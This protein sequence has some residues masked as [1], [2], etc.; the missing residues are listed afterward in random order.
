[1][2]LGI[3]TILVA[4]S[5]VATQA[6]PVVG[7]GPDMDSKYGKTCI[8][9][10]CHP[11]P[12]FGT[13]LKHPPYLEG[14]CMVCHE[15]H[16]SARPALLKLEGNGMCLSCHTSVEMTPQK[17]TL[18][19]PP[20]EQT[21]TAC[22]DPHESRVR[23]F[24]RRDELLHEC[25]G[26]H[27][28]FLKEANEKPYKHRFFE[29]V[30]ECG[31]CH[32]AHRGSKNKYLRKNLTESCLTCHDLPIQV[33]GRNLEN[34]GRNMR[35]API[36]HGA[37]EK[38][39]CETCHTPHGAQQPALLREGYPTGSY[40]TYKTE[41]YQLCWQC[42]SP[43][44]VE[45]KGDLGLTKF[46]NGDVNLHRVHVVE[47]KRGRACHVCHTSHTSDTPHLLRQEIRFHEW[48]APIGFE[49][50]TD[51]GSCS[52]PCHR[53]REYHRSTVPPAGGSESAPSS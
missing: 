9:A 10:E 28:E 37:L 41:D 31:S 7:T 42:H 51:G 34:V 25:A 33:D 30:T 32:F 13:V 44:L 43:D 6:Q 18:A 24:L 48:D 26:C 20:T 40:S 4:L 1:V 16:S 46:R 3:L 38:G 21:C 45:S 8:S 17:G 35:N 2:P 52:T 12:V 29:P 27:S 47:L 15:D 22:H 23:N 36:V 5:A 14:A 53:K 49:P 39:G 50:L 11:V 19:H